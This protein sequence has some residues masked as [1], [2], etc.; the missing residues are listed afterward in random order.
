MIQSKRSA[1]EFFSKKENKNIALFSGTK[2]Q[3]NVARTESNFEH[4]LE[5]SA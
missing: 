3:G 5:G 1:E 4:S 2:I